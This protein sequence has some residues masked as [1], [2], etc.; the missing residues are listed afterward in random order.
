LLTSKFKE[1]FFGKKENATKPLSKSTA[2]LK[3]LLCRI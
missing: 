1:V 2:Q 3:K